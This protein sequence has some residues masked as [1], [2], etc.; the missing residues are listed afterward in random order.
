MKLG[1]TLEQVDDDRTRELSKKG[2]Q[3]VSD[4]DFQSLSTLGDRGSPGGGQHVVELLTAAS[5][6]EP[7]QAREFGSQEPGVTGGSAQESRRRRRPQDLDEGVPDELEEVSGS[8]LRSGLRHQGPWLAE[9]DDG[10]GSRN[11]SHP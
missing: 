9:R 10:I 8:G 2:A 4:E 11:Q 3:G 7:V 1:L 6:L 5:D